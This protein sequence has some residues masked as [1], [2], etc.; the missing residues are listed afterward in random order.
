MAAGDECPPFSKHKPMTEE[1]K[2]QIALLVLKKQL[3]EE[4]I[5]LKGDI[6]RQIGDNAKKIGISTDEAME[7]SESLVRE[8]VDYAFPK[9]VPSYS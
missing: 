7:F 6:R 1:R 8:L 2:G 3:R 5:R 4:G 9:K